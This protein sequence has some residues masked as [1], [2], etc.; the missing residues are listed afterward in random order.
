MFPNQV[1][2]HFQDAARALG[3]AQQ[4]AY[5]LVSS[6]DFPVRTFKL[7]AKR[8]CNILDLAAVLDAQ[9]EEKKSGPG[10]PTNAETVRRKQAAQHATT[11]MA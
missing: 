1:N 6:G 10:R 4:T 3:M 11:G 7:G 9:R 2:I 5:N 8:A